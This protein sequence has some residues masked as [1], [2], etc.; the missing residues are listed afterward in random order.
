MLKK[1]RSGLRRSVKII[2]ED[3][4]I[5]PRFWIFT[6]DGSY[7]VFNPLPDDLKIR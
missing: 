3:N 1:L 2:K 5:R 4:E 6:H 7:I